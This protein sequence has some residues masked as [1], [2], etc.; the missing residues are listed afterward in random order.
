MLSSSS[1]SFLS[2]IMPFVTSSLPP[3][4]LLMNSAI[5]WR[6]DRRYQLGREHCLHNS[7]SIFCRVPARSDSAIATTTSVVVVIVVGMDYRCRRTKLVRTS[8]LVQ[9]HRFWL[10]ASSMFGLRCC[11]SPVPPLSSSVF[12]SGL[13]PP[14]SL[15]SFQWATPVVVADAVVITCVIVIGFAFLVSPYFFLLLREARHRNRHMD[16]GS[17]VLRSRDRC[18][19]PL[20]PRGPHLHTQQC[21]CCSCTSRFMRIPLV[22][23][24]EKTAHGSIRRSCDSGSKVDRRQPYQPM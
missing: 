3:L 20:R 23:G 21:E 13:S 8:S 9:T 16:R 2:S 6:R 10:L 17:R 18:R 14:S 22:A 24:I 12:S 4:C 7:S 15:A 5:D 19:L 1:P 11:S